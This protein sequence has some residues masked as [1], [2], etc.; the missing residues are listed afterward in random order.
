MA[1]NETKQEET[2]P[3]PEDRVPPPDPVA[4]VSYRWP[5]TL[6][7][8]GILA[9]CAYL[10]TLHF[11]RET[12]ELAGEQAQ[13]LAGKAEDIAGRFVQGDI[14]STFLTHIPSVDSAGGGR[15]ELATLESTETF[16]QENIK[17]IAWDYMSLGTTVTEIEVPVTYRYHI[18][19]SDP[20]K[21][22]VSEKTCLV[23]A[24]RIRP[25]QPPAIHTD[26]MK[27]RSNGGWLRFNREEQQ[28]KLERSI[29]PRLR[30]FALDPLRVQLVRDECRRTVARFVRDWLLKED[31]WHQDRFTSIKVVF[32]DEVLDQ[33]EIPTLTLSDEKSAP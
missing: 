12:L 15:L 20:W 19:L 4:H 24:P 7:A 6:V 16:R 28:E 2:K 10:G 25:T 11:G 17:T 8:F 30:L 31:Q 22:E 26:K 13:R 1:E 3:V 9:L 18:L 14:T 32:S 5:V 29:T 27:R 33:S 23:L 21:L